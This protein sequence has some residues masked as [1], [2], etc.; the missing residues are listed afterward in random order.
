MAASHIHDLMALML[1]GFVQGG[2]DRSDGG[3]RAARL[4]LIKK[5]ILDRSRDPSL[6]VNSVARRHGVTPRYVQ[7]LFEREG[8]TFTEFLRDSRLA[9]A[10]QRLEEGAAEMSIAQIALESGFTDLSN[11]NRV[12]RRR[13]G[14][15]PSDV[16]VEAMRNRIRR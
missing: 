15:T 5:D 4:E 14:L 3:I 11:F 6:S 7:Q 1:D 13:Y 2:S 10:Y 12:F 9:L 8:T 16:R